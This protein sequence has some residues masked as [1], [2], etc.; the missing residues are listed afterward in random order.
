MQ[1]LDMVKFR[2]SFQEFDFLGRFCCKIAIKR[3]KIDF[4]TMETCKSLYNLAK[5]TIDKLSDISYN[6]SYRKE[7]KRTND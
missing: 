5:N 7:K 4:S 6:N 3:S 1:D 2:F